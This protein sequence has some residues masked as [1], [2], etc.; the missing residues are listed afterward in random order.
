MSSKFKTITYLLA[1]LLSAELVNGT[2][3]T[4]ISPIV[5]ALPTGVDCKNNCLLPV[6]VK[7]IQSCSSNMQSFDTH[8]QC[9]FKGNACSYDDRLELKPE[10]KLAKIVPKTTTNFKVNSRRY[11]ENSYLVSVFQRCLTFADCRLQ[12]AD[13]RLQI[14]AD[15]R[16]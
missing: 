10:R 16:P 6:K 12:T 9:E 1:D 2:G 15:L 7:T 14:T 5:A 8:L 3:E 13:C 11:L 4:G